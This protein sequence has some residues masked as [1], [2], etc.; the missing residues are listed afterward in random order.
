MHWIALE[1]LEIVKFLHT[2]NLQSLG[3]PGIGNDSTET[4]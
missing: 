1:Y 2:A 3:E 4:I